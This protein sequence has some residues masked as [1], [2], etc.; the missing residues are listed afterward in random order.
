M[1]RLV[2][3]T[4]ALKITNSGGGLVD[5]KEKYKDTATGRMMKRIM[6]YKE[7]GSEYMTFI[8]PKCERRQKRVAYDVVYL[9]ENGDVVFYC[10]QYGCDAEIEVSRPPKA[11]EIPGSKLIMTPGEY[12][13]EQAKKSHGSI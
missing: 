10:N 13:Q 2:L 5:R 6:R 12:R 1:T 8:C 4:T 11:E 3:H 9:R 7:E